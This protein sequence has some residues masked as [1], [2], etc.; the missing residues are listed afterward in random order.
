M[1]SAI[2][3]IRNIKNGK[4]YI[5]SSS[6]IR[7]RIYSHKYHLNRGTHHC[8]PL[9][10]AWRKYG[11]DSFSF[12]NILFC[13][14][15][16]LLMFEQKAID[17]FSPEYNTCQIAGSS[18]GRHHSEETKNR[19]SEA[20]RGKK[21]SQSARRK[22]SLAKI[23]TK[24]SPETRMAISRALTGRKVPA[25]S[26]AKS[27]ASRRGQIRS[28]RSEEHCRKISL[29][30]RGRKLTKEHAMNISRGKS[31]RSRPDMIG[32]TFGSLRKGLRN[33]SGL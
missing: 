32:N 18:L 15:S 7:N 13:D 17:A 25:E 21:V 5:G 23:G 2:Y 4:R 10:R 29:A 27:A 28:P 14:P 3:E 16:N 12:R 11:K 22:M 20:N 26:V 1:Q 31:G 19:I 8:T 9:Q 6:N 33:E 30:L 24:A